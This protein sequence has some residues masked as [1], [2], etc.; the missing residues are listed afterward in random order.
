MLDEL[1]NSLWQQFGASIDMLMNAIGVCPS[2]MYKSNKRFF[3]TAYHVAVFLDYYLTVPQQT[4]SPNCHL[5]LWKRKTCQKMPWMM[6]CPM[7]TTPK[8]NF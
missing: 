2:T 5:L 4:L 6:C 1:K 8:N 3:Y 7:S